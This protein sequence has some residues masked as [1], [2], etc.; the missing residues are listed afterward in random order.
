MRVDMR[1]PKI[2]DR[3]KF[4]N[5]WYPTKTFFKVVDVQHDNYCATKETIVKVLVNRIDN[6]PDLRIIH[7]WEEEGDPEHIL[8][9]NVF[10]GMISDIRS[11]M[12]MIQVE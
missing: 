4:R 6:A 2:G 3:I 10:A 1:L 7:G 5:G 8:Y 11:N 12:E 9:W